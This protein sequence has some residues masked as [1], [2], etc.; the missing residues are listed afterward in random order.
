M[1]KIYKTPRVKC[2]AFSEDVLT[3][4]KGIYKEDDFDLTGFIEYN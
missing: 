3:E 1:K 4:S 2:I